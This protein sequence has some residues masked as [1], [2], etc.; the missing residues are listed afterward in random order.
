MST[1]VTAVVLATFARKRRVPGVGRVA[2]E[3]SDTVEAA[4]GSPRSLPTSATPLAS[5]LRHP[6]AGVTPQTIDVAPSAVPRPPPSYV[7]VVSLEA[8]TKRGASTIARLVRASGSPAGPHAA[9][10]SLS[11]SR[12]VA[13]WSA[14]GIES[15]HHTVSN[16][17]REPRGAHVGS[18]TK[19]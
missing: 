3:W 13:A 10:T 12:V 8:T 6:D 1:K 5:S 4:R 2:T 15:L 7:V 16:W 9:S 14:H 18:D 17:I 11:C 19:L